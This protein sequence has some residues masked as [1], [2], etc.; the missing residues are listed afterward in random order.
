MCYCSYST[1]DKNVLVLL[2]YVHM[3]PLSLSFL[4]Y[5]LTTQFLSLSSLTCGSKKKKKKETFIPKK[6]FLLSS[7]LL[8]FSGQIQ[9]HLFFSRASLHLLIIPFVVN[10]YFCL[11]STVLL[12]NIDNYYAPYKQRRLLCFLKVEMYGCLSKTHYFCLSKV[13]VT[14]QTPQTVAC[15]KSIST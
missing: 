14:C 13:T 12:N 1:H 8:S 9:Y 2:S 4:F 10:S 15:Q 11:C 7:F 3:I 6:L 5:F